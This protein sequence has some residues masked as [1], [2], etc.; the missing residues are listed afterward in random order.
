MRCTDCGIIIPFNKAPDLA[1][2]SI[3]GVR[4]TPDARDIL[5]H[6]KFGITKEVRP[7]Q[8]AMARDIE[9]VFRQ[10][11]GT[12]IGEG[13]TG[14]GKSFAYLIPALLADGKRV[15]I[16]T[17][18]KTLQDQLS[19]D[20]PML[21]KKMGIQN[22]KFGVY[23]GKSNYACWKLAQ[24]VPLN[25]RSKFNNFVDKARREN[26]P[27]DITHWK[28]SV[29]FWWS[30]ISIDNCAIG[31]R[32]AHFKECRPHPKNYH[33]VVTNHHLMAIDLKALP[34]TLFG[35]YNTL[36]ID[37]AHQAPE[38]FRSAYSRAITFKSLKRLQSAL[39][40]DDHLRGVVDDSGITSAA[41]LVS[42]L[43]A[44][45]TSFGDLHSK[46][47]QTTGGGQIVDVRRI[48]APLNDF[49]TQADTY[50]GGL[51]LLLE[52]INRS[53]NDSHE[54]PDRE[55]SP[56][57]LFAML[58]RATRLHKRVASLVEFA[59]DLTSRIKKQNESATLE[60]LT[61]CDDTGLHLQPLDIGKLIANPIG[62][63]KHKI[64]MSATLAMGKDFE[65]SKQRFGLTDDLKA[66]HE[67]ITEKIYPSPFDMAKQAV[68]YIPRHL[69]LPAHAGQPTERIKWIKALST[70]IAQLLGATRGD[71]F[72][73]FS[74]RA[75]MQAV[76]EELGPEH[77]DDA[78]LTL[79]E[80]EGEATA[81]LN[82]FLDTPNSVLFGLK[83]FWEGVDVPGDKLKLVIIPKL[84][85]PNPKDPLISA[86]SEQ[87]GNSSFMQVMV[88]HMFF[89]MKQGV[90]R[91]IR[92]Q[93]DK[94][95]VAILD[96]RVWTG[97]GNRTNHL[98]RM[99]NIESQHPT[100][101]KRLGYG[102]KLLD[103]LGFTQVTDDF[104]IVQT[105]VK[106]FFNT[107]NTG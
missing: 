42:G 55:D 96:P 60:F 40:M 32:C 58:S 33:I 69:P 13:G 31:N 14:I 61:T 22:I 81:T 84:P 63:V 91:L 79:V 71:A 106:K 53:Y 51:F 4:F 57:K 24:E 18:K 5:E 25:D 54:D 102:K 47:A 49:Q 11:H 6:G 74:A 93:S 92:T 52:D 65:F 76:I 101:R 66:K 104:T 27:A 38:A 94:G 9:E 29:P 107:V 80:Q 62:T 48:E 43:D 20:I 23:K 97:T 12:L 7:T 78:G 70:E 2:C 100:R 105:W 73:L 8:V 77:W 85:F 3:C 99:E 30:K 82:R 46:A 36:I 26:R 83:S 59:N 37:E 72:V 15:I 95:F 50:A 10:D 28:G 68:L 41:A 45:V 21:I 86:L 98:K 35:P 89:D 75:D 90:G 64:I 39:K 67:V 88:P 44:L 16:S 19:R 87:A 17:A 56:E 34:G 1:N 103:A